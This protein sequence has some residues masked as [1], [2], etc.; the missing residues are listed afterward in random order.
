MSEITATMHAFSDFI[1]DLG[2]MDIPLEGGLF[3]WSNNREVAAKSIIDRFL[4]SS[5]WAGHFGLVNLRRLLQLL[6][7]HF[8]I[9]LDCGCIIGG[10]RPFRFEN[11][12]F[13]VDGFVDRIKGWWDSYLVPGSPSHI[14]ASKLK[15]LKLDL[16]QWNSSEFGDIHF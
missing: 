7:N 2:L 1:V 15:A 9:L 4:F 8:P 16:K 11:M 13:K 12:W 14:M 10:K 5:D 3:T 6:S